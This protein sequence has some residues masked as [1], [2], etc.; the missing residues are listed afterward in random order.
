MTDWV[1]HG[2]TSRALPNIRKEGL[3]PRKQPRKH[4][5]EKRATDEP[6]I[7]FT[8][9]AD[10]AN[11]WGPVVL[12]FP[13][14]DES[15][16]DL[17]G[18]TTYTKEYGAIETNWYT[19]RWVPP[20]QIE[21]KTPKGWQALR[22]DPITAKDLAVLDEDEAREVFAGLKDGTITEP[23]VWQIIYRVREER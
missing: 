9:K 4:R 7:F 12:R 16:P 11:Y 20:E 5:G 22:G 23:D 19:G 21:M 8:I 17:Y 2:T 1:Y 14:P 15:E 6:V 10:S 13:W 18:D 3:V